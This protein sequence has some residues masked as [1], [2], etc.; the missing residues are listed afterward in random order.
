VGLPASIIDKASTVGLVSM[1]CG[2]IRA[3]KAG[4]TAG[5]ALRRRVMRYRPVNP[6]MRERF[7]DAPMADRHD[8]D[9]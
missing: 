4:S 6:S 9:A 5:H 1:R 2:G 3:S 7:T 8:I